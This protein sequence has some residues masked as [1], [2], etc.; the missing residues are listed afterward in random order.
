VNIP[1]SY[2]A[3]FMV[4]ARERIRDVEVLLNLTS[5]CFVGITVFY[6]DCVGLHEQG[7]M[8]MHGRGRTI[9]MVSF[10]S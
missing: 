7:Q 1:G 5:F 10:C 2:A 6:N 4:E 8:Q 9:F 3:V